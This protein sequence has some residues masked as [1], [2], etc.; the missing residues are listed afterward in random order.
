[1]CFCCEISEEE[2]RQQNTHAKSDNLQV[3]RFLGQE[4]ILDSCATN[5]ATTSA[6]HLQGQWNSEKEKKL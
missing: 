5:M 1:M 4:N 3:W 6:G 2:K